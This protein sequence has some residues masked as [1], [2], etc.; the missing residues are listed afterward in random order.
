VDHVPVHAGLDMPHR[1]IDVK[2]PEQK[3]TQRLQKQPTTP[4][5]TTAHNRTSH[6]THTIYTVLHVTALQ[7]LEVGVNG[8]GLVLV[9]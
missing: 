5:H 7:D 4:H 1:T 3:L 9:P 8:M 2:G 6:I